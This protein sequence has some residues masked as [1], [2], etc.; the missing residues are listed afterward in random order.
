MLENNPSEQNKQLA[1]ID[2]IIKEFKE[3]FVAGTQ[4]ADSFLTLTEIEKM[5]GDLQ[6]QTNNIYSDMIRE[7]LSQVDEKDL[8]RKKKENTN[9]LESD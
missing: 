3:K 1:E 7:M 5:W 2:R 8:I 6:N 4:S 9:P